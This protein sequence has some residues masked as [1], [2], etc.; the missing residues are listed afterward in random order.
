[1]TAQ[2][3]VVNDREGTRRV[4]GAI[5]PRLRRSQKGGG[6]RLF[7]SPGAEPRSRRATDLVLLI[8]AVAGTTAF[9]FA[10]EPPSH[11]ESAVIGV[12][13][14]LPQFLDGRVGHL[15]RPR[16]HLGP[17]P[18]RAR[19]GTASLDACCATCCCLPPLQVVWECSSAGARPV[20]GRRSPTTSPRSGLPARVPALRLAMCAAVLI[21]ASPHLAHPIRRIGH[22]MVALASFSIVALS[23]TTPSG[24]ILALLLASGA[25]SLVHLVFGS[26]AGR[27]GVSDVRAA[28]SELGV[29]METL[30]IA[31]RQVAG[32]FTMTGTDRAGRSVSVRVYG[33]DAWDTQ[34]VAKTWRAVWYR[35]SD[36]ITLTRAQ[37]AEHEAFLTLLAADH[38]VNVPRVI[39]AGRTAAQR[40]APRPGRRRRTRCARRAKGAGRSTTSSSRNCGT[41]WRSST[42]PTSPT[43]TSLPSSSASTPTDG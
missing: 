31:T 16:G 25:A 8:V 4:L 40:R 32:V 13:D 10:A 14:A 36:P 42:R 1:M 17:R 11:I 15:L 33:R 22:W 9:A 6:L 24:A 41:W 3:D 2:E 39:T 18:D 35:D 29:E 28:L 26:T 7:S 23:A 34:L 12:F 5:T 38:G 37:Q 19:R 21:T 43:P 20:S 30:E 27:P